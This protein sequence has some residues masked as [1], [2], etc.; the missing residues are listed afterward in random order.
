MLS[1][2][3]L[4]TLRDQRRSLAWWGFGMAVLTIITVLFYPS[5]REA[6]EFNQIVED[7]G[8]L[9]QAFI[10]DI[11]DLTSPEGFL[12][13]QLYFF[14]VPMLYLVFAIIQGSGTVAGEEERGTLDLLLSHPIARATAIMQKFAAMGVSLLVF[15]AVLWA[16]VAI[17]VAAVDMDLSLGRVAEI[18]ISGMLLGLVFG[19][20]ALAIGCATGRRGLSAG[21]A[22]ALGVIAYFINAFRLIVGALESAGKTS[23]FYLYIGADPL[24][25]GLNVAHVGIMIGIILA[26]LALAVVAFDRRDLAV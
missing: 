9:A 7:L 12:N 8:P 10:G 15:S 21:L 4:K 19:T 18:T 11:E 17:G 24:S 6:T 1:N 14:L 5:F 22:G 3:I 25:N 16:S 2:L 26:L 13:S 20:C 23:P